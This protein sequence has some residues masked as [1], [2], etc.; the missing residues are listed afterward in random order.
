LLSVGI[1]VALIGAVGKAQ[2]TYTYTVIADLFNCD[3][4]GVPALNNNGEVA[5]GARCGAPIGPT[6]SAFLIRRGEGGALTPIHTGSGSQPVPRIDVVSINDLGVV[7]FAVSGQCPNAGSGAIWTGSGGPTAVV[8]DICTTPGFK[9]VIRPSISNTGAVAFMAASGGGGYDFVVRSKDGALVTIAGPGSATT[10]LGPLTAAN[11]PSI[12]NNDVVTFMGQGASMPGLFTGSGGA[13][14]TIKIGNASGFNP[15]NDSGRVAFIVNSSAVQTGDGG[16]LTT[17][18]TTT[19]DGGSYQRFA[20]I[21]SINAAGKV[22]F[23]ATLPSGVTGVFTGPDPVASVVLKEGDVIPGFGTVALVDMSREAINDNGQV[24]M[25]VRFDDSGVRKAAIIRADPVKTPPD[26]PTGVSGTRGNAQ[27]TVSFTPPVNNGGSLVTSYT[28]TASP[29]GATASGS[30]SPLTVTGLTNGTPYTFTV[31][32]T[33]A[34][35]T[36]QPSAPSAPVTPATTPGPPTDVT[37]ARGNGQVTVSFTAPADNGGD[38]ITSY[39]VTASPG[40]ADAS[41]SA[42][43]I[44]VTGL[45]NGTAYTLTV[46]ATNSVGVGTASRPSAAVTPATIPGAPT[47]IVGTRGN[48]QVSVSFTAPS[49]NGGDPITSYTVTASPGGATASGSASPIV[50]TGL[51]NGASHTFTVRATN[52]VGAGPASAAS[53]AVTPATVPDAPRGVSAIAGNAQAILSFVAPVTN[54][55]AAITGYTVTASP[56]GA[57]VSGSASPITVTGLTNGTIYTFTV[58]ANNGAGSS[59]PSDP[60]N[61]VTPSAAPGTPLNFTVAPSGLSL[62]ATWTSTGGAA[63]THRLEVATSAAFSS[64]IFTLPLGAEPFVSLNAPPGTSGTFFF[65]MTAINA[66]GSSAPAGP[67]SATLPAPSVPPG[68]PVLHNAVIAGNNVALNWSPTAGGAPANYLLVVGSSAGAANVGEFPM[69]TF[70]SIS[71]SAPNGMYFARVQ[72]SNAVGTATS[73]EISFSVGPPCVV[74]TPPTGASVSR[75]G[76]IITVSWGAPAGGSSPFTYTIVAGSTAGASNLGTF[77]VGSVTTTSSGVPAGFYFLRV[78]ATNAC[79]TSGNSS[80]V[81]IVVP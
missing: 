35:G 7:A 52:G 75:S 78:R 3:L 62:L 63:T 24:A 12:N 11:E 72:A 34:I 10:S 42:G 65:R 60:S 56:G 51:T 23:R 58:T 18:A 47:S 21:S 31:R 13:L 41:G 74:P 50:V 9:S 79:G 36:G 22:A 8:H 20:T 1:G 25:V 43:P 48:G 40:G 80:E 55:G 16:P 38:P 49:D 37:G 64:I 19:F 27:V 53:A 77:P 73:N 26:A 59:A 68:P 57:S 45:T 17:I 29:G 81:S 4:Q 70:T 30:S 6:T 46:R 61:A 14:T 76:G 66:F 32:A 71:S 44:V 69:G 54:G 39:T 2:T 67:V 33:N 5:F 15:I 28:A